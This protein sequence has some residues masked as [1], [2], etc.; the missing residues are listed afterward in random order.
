MQSTTCELFLTSLIT[1]LLDTPHL[2][3]SSPWVIL[4]SA[5]TKAG[6]GREQSREGYRTQLSRSHNR[7]APRDGEEK[8]GGIP[9]AG[10]DEK[11]E[12]WISEGAAGAGRK[13]SRFPLLSLSQCLFDFDFT[14]V[15]PDSLSSLRPSRSTAFS[16]S[17]PRAMQFPSR[18]TSSANCCFSIT[19]SVSR[20]LNRP[21][22]ATG[23]HLDTTD[24]FFLKG[25]HDGI[26]GATML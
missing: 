16:R 12:G 15:S 24:N 13:L 4:F 23:R 6:G 14:G 9:A 19:F 11:L 25:G 21:G 22:D 18:C 20:R 5:W 1:C 3:L 8:L 2:F 7:P 26:H 10:G 17:S